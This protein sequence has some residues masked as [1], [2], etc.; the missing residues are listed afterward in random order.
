MASDESEMRSFLEYV[1][2]VKEDLYISVEVASQRLMDHIVYCGPHSDEVIKGWNLLFRV[3]D[4]LDM[5]PSCEHVHPGHLA[6]PPPPEPPQP[7]QAPAQP[8]EEAICLSFVFV[9]GG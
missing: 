6:P 4:T 2:E 7:P 8:E 3:Q 9:S 5:M 1:R